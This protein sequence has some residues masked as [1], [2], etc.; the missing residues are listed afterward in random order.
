MSLSIRHCLT[1][2]AGTPDPSL[3][4]FD[5][6]S[7][8][9]KTSYCNWKLRP[10]WLP[11]SGKISSARF[12]FSFWWTRYILVL[13]TWL[14][15]VGFPK[16]RIW[17]EILWIPGTK[18]THTTWGSSCKSLELNYQGHFGKIHRP[19]ISIHTGENFSVG[20]WV[21]MKVG[22]VRSSEMWWDDLEIGWL[23]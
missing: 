20:G 9:Q 10:W 18:L 23:E 8:I 13:Q 21:A 16:I 4:L 7:T 19:K 14:G 2:Q 22:Q 6:K 1:T 11:R 12:F 15:A 17:S 5:Q 3:I